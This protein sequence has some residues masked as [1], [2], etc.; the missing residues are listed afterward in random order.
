[1]LARKLTIAVVAA[2]AATLTTPAFA[3]TPT[4]QTPS[5]PAPVAAPT[6]A[7]AAKEP[8]GSAP[9]YIRDE[10]PEERKVRLGTSEDPGPN[11]D[12]N[13]HF[14]RFGESYHV[15]R[16]TR[17]EAVINPNEPTVAR[18]MYVNFQY[19]IY[20][21]SDDYVWVWMADP[22]PAKPTDDPAL[23]PPVVNTRWQPEH[24]AFFKRI[25]PEFAALTPE[26]SG[27]TIRFEQSSDGLPKS[28]SW[29]NSLAVADMN[30][31]GCPDIVTPP[32]RKGNSQ[33]QIFL[34][35]CKGHWHKW[36][37]VSFPHGIDYGGVVAADFNKDGKM[38]LAFSVHL[39]GVYVFLG[40]GKGH[41]TE[42]T[43]G[44]PRDYPTRR[45]AVA[46]VDGDGYP[47]LI[48]SSEG[49]T[50]LTE[51][52]VYPAVVALL[53]RKHGMAW[54]RLDIASQDSRIG[55]DWLTVGNF[56]GDR[57]PDVIASSVFFGSWDVVHLSDGP[58]HWKTVASDGDLIPSMS[59]YLA[60]AAG[61]FTKGARVD[62]A[63]VSYTRFW[64]NDLDSRIL[65]TPEITELTNIDRLTFTKD[66]MKRV[67]IMR[68]NGHAGVRGVATGDFD[69]DGNLDIIVTVEDVNRRGV[70]ILLGDGK[71]NFTAANIDGLS[72]D[73]NNL[74][75]VKVADVNGDG[76]PDV[77]LMYE[78]MEIHREDYL[79]AAV[80]NR[81]GSIKVFL[82]RGVT[83]SDASQMKAAK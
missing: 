63:I 64:P 36:E 78:T 4:A 25:R 58:R 69:G 43:E 2:A 77:I 74:Y 47:D 26:P 7:A 41:F 11:P 42:S 70:V 46:D 35:D 57:V 29:R 50:P 73:D 62:D 16:W 5:A 18:H 14:M 59:Y 6:T 30:G 27:K 15:S 10:T 44:L 40:D 37:G 54:E 80:D 56:N 72:L 49:P 19:E 24:I 71:G 33:P 60:S 48:I 12:P 51:Q 76:R 65:A 75:D 79:R 22:P 45:L 3:Q 53:N 38:D 17:R 1:M 68:W 34:G 61:K 81:P 28:G 67:P 52:P 20:Q 83:K 9:H 32:E 23:G 21:L 8:T 55:G 39:N 31:D 13:K 66:G 82:N